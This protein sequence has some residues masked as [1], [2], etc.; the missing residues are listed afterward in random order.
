MAFFDRAKQSVKFTDQDLSKP[1]EPARE[2]EFT[3]PDGALD[4]LSA[5]YF[6]RLQKLKEGEMLR[7]PVSANATNYQFEIEVQKR[8][9]L[10]L[11]LG[12]FRTIKLKPK[13]FGPGQIFSRPG[14]MFMWVTDDDRHMPVRLTAKTATGTIT[15]TLV[16]VERPKDEAQNKKKK[17]ETAK[18]TGS[19]K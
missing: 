9:K 17:I 11:D 18:N 4:L 13:L 2:K 6:V 1:Q 14:E 15:A 3:T 10:K 16:K 7:F 5:F 19:T 8:E 12:K